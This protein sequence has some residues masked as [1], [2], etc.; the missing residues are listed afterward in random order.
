MNKKRKSGRPSK[1]PKNVLRLPDLDLAKSAVIW[2][3]ARSTAG[4][5]RFADSHTK[6]PIPDCSVRNWRP[7]SAV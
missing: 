1:Q 4:W 3:Q 7:E 2:R 6:P 5:R